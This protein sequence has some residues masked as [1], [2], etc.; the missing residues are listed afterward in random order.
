MKGQASGANQ[1]LAS[2]LAKKLEE[3]SADLSVPS[4][5]A[6]RQELLDV[7]IQ[8]KINAELSRLR[9]QE[10]E[11]QKKIE[12][13]LEKENIEREGKPWFG[14]D[15]GQSSKLLQEELTRVKTKIEKYHKRDLNSFP[16]LK[17]AREDVVKCYRYVP[18]NAHRSKDKTR[19]LDCWREV[20][21]FRQALASAESELMA[22]WK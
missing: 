13:A 4:P 20:E 7:S 12:L 5:D 16:S 6:R 21:T 17:S 1:Q 8:E 9:S 19:T 10:Q 15:K 14:K 11:M 22:A 18:A 2:T 3:T